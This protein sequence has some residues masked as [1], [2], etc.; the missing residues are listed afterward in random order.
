MGR[1]GRAIYDHDESKLPTVKFSCDDCG[2]ITE[3]YNLCLKCNPQKYEVHNEPDPL[4][5]KHTI[6]LD[7]YAKEIWNAAIEEA[8]KWLDN[9]HG[10]VDAIEIRK[11]K[12]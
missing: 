7:A 6:A 9:N 3:G 10:T 12:K 11:L 8:A 4:L 5:A 2:T 1:N